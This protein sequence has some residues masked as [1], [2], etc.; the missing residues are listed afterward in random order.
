MFL[1]DLYNAYGTYA[2]M[3][4]ELKLGNSTY[5]GWKKKGYIPYETQCSIQVKTHGRFKACLEHGQPKKIMT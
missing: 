1:I 4:R 3:T 2:E 5:L